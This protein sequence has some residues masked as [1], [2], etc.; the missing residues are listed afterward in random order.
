ML[1]DYCGYS[2]SKPER[3][4]EVYTGASKLERTSFVAG[5]T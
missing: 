2:K 3:A 4:S 5:Y 1:F